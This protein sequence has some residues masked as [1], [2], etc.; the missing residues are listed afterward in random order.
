MKNKPSQKFCPACGSPNQR[1]AKVC[2]QCGHRFTAASLASAQ[3]GEIVASKLLHELEKLCPKCGTINKLA[4]KVCIQC[5]HHFRTQFKQNSLL[6]A[7]DS[8]PKVNEP[9]ITQDP[10]PPLTLPQEFESPTPTL[11]PVAD[12]TPSTGNKL[13][14]ELAPD[15]SNDELD[16]LR[17]QSDENIA[18]YE[19]LQ[20]SLQRKP[21]KP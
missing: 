16:T 7:V 4:A 9:P 3:S 17:E 2:V 8:A 20:R 5:G 1:S 12:T 11:P 15:M 14:G 10:E 13:E 19:R 21:R 18:P 6:D